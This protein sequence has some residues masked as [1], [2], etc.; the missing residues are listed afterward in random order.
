MKM[1][2]EISTDKDKSIL[3]QVLQARGLAEESL[4]QGLDELPDEALLANIEKAAERVREALYKNEPLVIFGHDDPDGVTSTYILYRFLNSLGYQKHHYYIPNRIIEH[5]GIQQS[6]I[7]FVKAG[8][9]PLVITVDNGISS[10]TGVEKL[11]E[12]GCDVIVTDHH[13]I[14]PDS[15]P[16]AYAIVNPQ[17]EESQYP[18]KMLA[19]VGV[20]LMFIRYLGRMLEHPVNPA[21]YFWAAIGS[22]ADKVPMTGINRIIVRYVLENWDSIGDNTKDFLQRNHNR[23]SSITDKTNFLQYCCRLIA[24]GREADGQH[25]AMK[26]LMQRSDE[27]VRLFQLLE[28]EKNGWEGALNSVFKL[29]DTLMDEYTGEAFIYYDDEDLIPY[30]LLGTAATYVVNNLGI[31]AIFLKK[32]NDAMVCEGRCNHS[33]NM[34]EAFTFCKESLIQFGGHAKAAGFTM[35]PENYNNF[36]E[37]FHLFLRNHSDSLAGGHPLRIDAITGS[38]SISNRFWYDID[39]L[40]P[41]GQENPEPVILVTN[42]R[43]GQLAERF[44]FDNSSISV[45]VDVIWDIAIQ[46]KGANLVKILDYRPAEQVSSV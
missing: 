37:L 23:V 38:D 40:L 31:P 14:Q 13:L 33:F 2:W 20:T 32:R 17:L 44:S 16:K 43:I 28:E 9:Y 27:K 8:K 12:L 45:P 30:T 42:C 39:I 10:N 6:F 3:E 19:G 18:F 4:G 29:V 34:V 25:L 35:L 1:N 26:F 22:I 46:L 5:H 21:L 15:L 24:N 41:Y 7:D 11:N 36:I